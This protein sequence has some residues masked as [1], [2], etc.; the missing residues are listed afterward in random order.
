MNTKETRTKQK[1]VRYTAGIAILIILIS[2]IYQWKNGLVIDN[3]ENLSLALIVAI[4]LSSFIPER[5]NSGK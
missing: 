2:F 5:K 1:V 3:T 4:F